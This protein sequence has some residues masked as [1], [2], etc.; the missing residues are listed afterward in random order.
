[1]EK[2]PKVLFPNLHF[3]YVNYRRLQLMIFWDNYMILNT[4]SIR[5]VFLFLIAEFLAISTFLP[6][7]DL[8]YNISSTEPCHFTIVFKIKKSSLFSHS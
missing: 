3:I 6:N 7:P 5:G 2:G 1:M 4:F 8:E